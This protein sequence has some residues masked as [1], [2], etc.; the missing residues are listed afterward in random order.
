M[1]NIKEIKKNYNIAKTLTPLI[2]ASIIGKKNLKELFD[3]VND[4]VD[5]ILSETKHYKDLTKEERSQINSD[6]YEIMSVILA[7]EVINNNNTYLDEAQ[8]ELIGVLEKIP[9]FL[10]RI[11]VEDKEIENIIQVGIMY[12]IKESYMFHNTLY[13]S[14]HLLFQEMKAYNL[15]TIKNAIKN[16]S[17]LLNYIKEN[18]ISEKKELTSQNFKI[19]GYLYSIGLGSLF[20]IILKDEDKIEDYKRNQDKYLKKVDKSFIENYGILTKTTKIISKNIKEE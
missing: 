18:K 1:S 3:T 5:S 19:C 14:D 11:K 9:N 6:L 20:N 12:I 13:L 2:N 8:Y 4:S 15:K 10:K 7:N 16:I 17:L